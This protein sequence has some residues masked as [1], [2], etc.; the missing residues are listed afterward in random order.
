M[1]R[2]IYKRRVSCSEA[3][4]SRR[5]RWTQKPSAA[6]DEVESRSVLIPEGKYNEN[7]SDG[8]VVGGSGCAYEGPFL[9]I[10]FTDFG[11]SC[12][13]ASLIGGSR[14]NLE[15]R[16]A[17]SPHHHTDTQHFRQRHHSV[18]YRGEFHTYR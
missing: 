6:R 15:L 11:W 4:C 3:E 2:Q 12:A 17:K 16:S 1:Y 7:K 14:A 8:P 9:V 13:V 10:C 5:A 18:G